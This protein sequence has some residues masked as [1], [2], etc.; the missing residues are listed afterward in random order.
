MS[1]NNI[2]G[3]GTPLGDRIS[4]FK[5]N[6]PYPDS[7][8]IQIKELRKS[9]ENW[10]EV[11]ISLQKFLIWE[12]QWYPLAIIGA[13]TAVFMFLW[14]SETSILTIISIIGLMATLCDYLIPAIS[15]SLFSSQ[16]WTSDKE[17]ILE[18][19]CGDI[20]I[21]K[22]QIEVNCVTYYRM[23]VT[24]PKLYFALTTVSLAFLA[25]LGNSFNNLF[26]MYMGTTFLLLYPG[27]EHTGF[28]RRF[29][30]ITTSFLRDYI[31]PRFQNLKKE[32]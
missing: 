22:T 17:A 32:N 23:R 5:F 6:I 31:N 11:I 24:N 16:K 21:C 30:E 26:L 29:K 19:I 14:L 15:S 1:T 20:I 3:D 13:S 4:E 2:I 28:N 10:K 18:G 27:I 9:L 12:K 7:L 25:W 8:D